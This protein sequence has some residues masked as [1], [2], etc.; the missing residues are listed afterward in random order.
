MGVFGNL[1]DTV[2]NIS[3][4]FKQLILRPFDPEQNKFKAVLVGSLLFFKDSS[5]AMFGA[6]S[7]VLG[8]LKDGM[9][10]VIQSGLMAAEGE[11]NNGAGSGEYV[12]KDLFDDDME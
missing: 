10:F 4:A 6:F 3:T 11:G 9:L 8:S 7:G 1:S 12:D 2:S 5:A